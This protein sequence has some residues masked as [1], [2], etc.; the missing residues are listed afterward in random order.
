M[1][2]NAMDTSGYRER[3]TREVGIA[4]ATID[5]MQ[6]QVPNQ[7]TAE[8]DR[9]ATRE[10]GVSDIVW[11]RV[12]NAK[13]AATEERKT[14]EDLAQR[15]EEARK[16]LIRGQGTDTERLRQEYDAIEEKYA[17]TC[18]LLQRKEKIQEALR[19]MDRCVYGYVWTREGG[20]YRC[21][22]GMQRY[23]FC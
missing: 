12:Q 3:S 6:T 10:D 4:H 9:I 1:S 18:E 23:A 7:S 11:E 8:G 17:K 15:R 22:G 20:G 14:F 13:T 21:E 2:R 5:T 16:A 19:K